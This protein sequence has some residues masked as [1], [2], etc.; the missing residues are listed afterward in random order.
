[1]KTGIITYKVSLRPFMKPVL[2]IAAILHIDW[3]ENLC[4]K[5]ELIL[6]GEEV[7]ISS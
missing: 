7:E 6:E 4:F 1:M 2:I 5:K 3:L